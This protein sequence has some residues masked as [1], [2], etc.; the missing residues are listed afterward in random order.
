[1]RRRRKVSLAAYG[2]DGTAYLVPAE[3]SLWQRIRSKLRPARLP[4]GWEDVGW[5]DETD[6]GSKP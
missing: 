3:P 4:K 1:M 6:D 2:E 5:I